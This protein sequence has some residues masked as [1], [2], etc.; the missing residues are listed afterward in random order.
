MGELRVGERLRLANG[1]T[2]TVTAVSIERPANPVTTYNLEVAD[3]HTYHV[4]GTDGWVFVH[5]T[6]SGIG[7]Y[8]TTGGHHIHAKAAFRGN[9]NYS[10][11]EA[12]S[13]SNDYMIEH[14]INHTAATGAQHRLF[15]ALAQSGQDNTMK[16]Q[17]QIAVRALREGGANQQQARNL[18]ASSLRN[19]RRQ[20]VTQPTRVPWNG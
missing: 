15:N 20:G 14:G 9:P 1:G 13:I 17:N 11:R 12:L 10:P 19:L 3:W 7:P 6:C 5:N 18:V 2:A 4:G 16:L 8:K